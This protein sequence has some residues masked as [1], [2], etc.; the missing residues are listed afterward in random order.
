[1]ST[2]R[3]SAAPPGAA[4]SGSAVTNALVIGAALLWG[5]GLLVQRGRLTWPP[6]PLLSS[7]ATLAGCLALVGPVILFRSGELEGSLGELGWLT[8]GL[9]HWAFDLAAVLQGQWR[10]IQWATP[11]PDRTLGLIILAVLLAGWRCG[12]AHRNW[13][14]TNVA[15]WM[16]CAFWVGMAAC[17]W[18]LAPGARAS[19]AVL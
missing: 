15:G 14:W 17:S 16:L 6:Y 19:L 11:L 7:L 5:A 4:S 12:L 8:A 13:S 2:K 1:M 10:T 3:P 9:L 18:L